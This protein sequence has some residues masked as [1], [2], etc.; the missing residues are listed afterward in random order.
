MDFQS[1]IEN[2]QLVMGEP[3]ELCLEQ[4]SFESFKKSTHTIQLS[5]PNFNENS[6]TFGSKNYNTSDNKTILGF[7]DNF[8]DFEENV[9]SEAKKNKV[10]TV[11]FFNTYDE[12]TNFFMK[13]SHILD[14]F[15]TTIDYFYYVTN[16]VEIPESE[17]RD[18]V[19]LTPPCLLVYIGKRKQVEMSLDLMGE[20]LLQ[21]LRKIENNFPVKQKF[22]RNSEHS[23]GDNN[24]NRGKNDLDRITEKYFRFI[25]KMLKG[26]FI[27]EREYF[28]MKSLFFQDSNLIVNSCLESLTY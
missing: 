22:H 16:M 26:K 3:Y 1:L 5:F 17:L 6:A 14:R 13:F 25:E 10:T 4:N 7:I 8:S 9:L 27:I 23:S 12:S 18:K 19:F 24:S 21:I 2:P 20:N 11:F 28:Y 15:I